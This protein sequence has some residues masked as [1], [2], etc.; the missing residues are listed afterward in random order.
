MII[1][2]FPPVGESGVQRPLKFLKYLDKAGWDTYVLTP[3]RP[4]KSVLDVSLCK[5]IPK[6][7]KIYRTASFGISGRSGER[8]SSLKT[9]IDASQSSLKKL[10]ACILSG[11]NH[12]LF[13][14]D[15]QIGW[16]PFALLK[17][18]WLIRRH[19]INNV[20]ITAFP[21]SAFLVGFFLKKIFGSKIRWVADY[22]DTWQ[23][24][25]L[26]LDSPS[27][28]HRII[29]HWDE[30]VL[31]T[32]D[33]AVFVTDYIR[34]RYLG[35]YPWLQ[36][37]SR[38]ITNGF[39]EADFGGLKPVQWE[40]KTILYMGKLYRLTTPDPRPLL[41]ALNKWQGMNFQL[42]HIGSLSS[43]VKAATDMYS[44]YHYY[45]YKAHREALEHALGADINLLLINDDEHS[46]GTF[47]GKLFELLRLGKPI[48]VL[49]PADGVARDLITQ[50]HAGE[51]A[52]LKNE[53]EILCALDRLVSNV[54]S[55]KA[56]SSLISS[57]SREK[58]CGDLIKLY[59]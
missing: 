55:Y 7:S 53:D 45:G 28:R 22:R 26:L 32:C 36:E 51:Y 19:K 37:K 47:S 56:D 23:F 4:P 33:R 48:L 30:K 3:R 59:E 43:E 24:E 31:R 18:V 10:K 54:D 38:V 41:R 39:D 57:Y 20:Y 13:P 9:S 35:S 16:V 21:Y 25:Q 15:K 8:F 1:N 44:F 50:S 46:A 2:E 12:L 40:K 27:W 42:A 58:L 5:E 14:L 29:R 17:A 11:L 52:Q 6:R 49:G 34:N